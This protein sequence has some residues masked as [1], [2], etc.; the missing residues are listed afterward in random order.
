MGLSGLIQKGRKSLVHVDSDGAL[1]A[2]LVISFTDLWA[3]KYGLDRV[4]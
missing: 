2:L 4:L 3:V 1:E